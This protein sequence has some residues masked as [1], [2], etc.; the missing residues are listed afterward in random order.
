[1]C[2]CMLLVL[3]GV[4][5]VLLCVFVCVCYA[6]PLRAERCVA[7]RGRCVRAYQHLVVPI[8]SI[9]YSCDYIVLV[10]S[11]HRVTRLQTSSGMHLYSLFYLALTHH[12]FQL[13]VYTC[14]SY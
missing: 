13:L 3:I 9:I 11:I 14:M 8:I 4:W 5:V 7:L 6:C 10:M 1:M 12:S 2:A